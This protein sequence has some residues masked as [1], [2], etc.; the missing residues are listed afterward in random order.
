M[1]EPT[2]LEPSRRALERDNLDAV[3][4]YHRETKHHFSH[5]ARGPGRLDWANQPDPFRRYEGASLSFLPRLQPG[6]APVSP[7]YE[8]LYRPGAIPSAAL[9]ACSLSRL[10][11]YSLA[12]SAWK[13]AGDVR[14]ALRTNPSSGN[15]HPTEAYL[16]IG[17]IAGLSTDPALHHYAAKEHA[18]ELRARWPNDSFQHLLQGFPHGAFLLGLTSVLWRGMP[19]SDSIA[20][21][22]I[23]AASR[24]AVEQAALGTEQAGIGFLMYGS[25][26]SPPTAARRL[27]TNHILGS[28]TTRRTLVTDPSPRQRIAAAQG[29]AEL[30]RP[31]RALRR[32][33]AAAGP[34]Q[35]RDRATHGCRQQ[36]RAVLQLQPA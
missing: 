1:D 31:R 28:G 2:K 16:L 29:P 36:Q 24:G 20:A 35:R 4:R 26:Q 6:D 11:E 23:S 22:S 9:S 7:R 21:P 18:L 15:L 34:G 25:T 27:A 3:L 17:R 13:Q 33:A 10:F 14:W 8:D 30:A 12:I 32:Q 5:F 19:A